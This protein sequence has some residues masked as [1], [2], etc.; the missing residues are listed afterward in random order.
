MEGDYYTKFVGNVVI[1]GIVVSVVFLAFIC[2][3]GIKVKHGEICTHDEYSNISSKTFDNSSFFLD[4]PGEY[5]LEH[6]K[7]DVTG[8]ISVDFCFNA[9]VNG[10]GIEFSI[11]DNLN[12]TLGLSYAS[13]TFSRYCVPLDAGLVS[14]PYLGVRCETC[15]SSHTITIHEELLGF[16]NQYVY[17]NNTELQHGL[18][19]ALSYRV[20]THNDC[21]GLLRVAMYSHITIM[22]AL[23][24]TIGILVGYKGMYKSLIEG[25]D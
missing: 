6:I 20:L 1:I 10:T 21:V 4:S 5:V 17:W 22:L 15:N 2:V 14:Q 7:Y 24:L 8:A 3:V 16:D 12:R 23:A 9:F 25:W 13:E 18:T 19:S 11:I